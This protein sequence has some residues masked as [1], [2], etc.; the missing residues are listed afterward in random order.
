MHLKGEI[1]SGGA[2][3]PHVRVDIAL[4]GPEAPQGTVIGSLSTDAR[5]VY[6]GAVVVPRDFALGEYELVVVTPGDARCAPSRSR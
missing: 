5:G 1:V 2:P 4:I 6:D 3:C